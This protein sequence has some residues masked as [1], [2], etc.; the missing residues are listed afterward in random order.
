[1]D[2]PAEGR[3]DQRSGVELFKFVAVQLV[4]FF[5]SGLQLGKSALS[6]FRHSD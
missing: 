2:E 3:T 1:M 4:F 6:L 5:N